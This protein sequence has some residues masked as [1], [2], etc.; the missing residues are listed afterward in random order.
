M[1]KKIAIGL[2]IVG[3]V[4]ASLGSVT[5][6]AKSNLEKREK[7]LLTQISKF[8]TNLPSA[9]KFEKIQAE[10]SLF[11]SKGKYVF[12]NTSVDKT[13]NS[14]ISLDYQAS[15]GPS[16]WFG[17]DIQ[18]V[19]DG[20][21]EG[22]SV[23][24][25]QIST[26]TNPGITFKV[27]GLLSEDSS[28]VSK[29]TV[30]DFN[31]TIPVPEYQ[32]P[33]EEVDGDE[34]TKEEVKKELAKDTKTGLYVDVKG[35][36][37]LLNF[38]AKTGEIQSEVNLASINGH[39]LEDPND[40]FV[41]KD[42]KV[43]YDSNINNIDI[44]IFK[45][46]AATLSNGTDNMK[47]DG[48]EFGINTEQKNQKYNM[49]INAKVQKLNIMGQSAAFEFG[50]S[51]HGIDKAMV[52][53]STKLGET[54]ASRAELSQ[55]DID[56]AREVLLNNLKTGFSINIDKAYLKNEKNELNYSAQ[57]QVV[58]TPKDQEFSFQNQSKFGF[59]F[60]VSGDAAPM[61]YSVFSSFLGT[62]SPEA[63]KELHVKAS[64][65][66][67]ALKINEKNAEPSMNETI[68]KGLKNI[69]IQL[70][71]AKDESEDVTEEIIEGQSNP[72]IPS[73]E[74]SAE[75]TKERR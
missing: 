27:E 11:S 37:G 67:G 4:A 52:D 46:K 73:S 47:I 62:T 10:S 21:V 68:L 1:N 49:K 48:L 8:K 26:N 3:I 14:Q 7:V 75:E 42:L 56:A 31:F 32:S 54:Y 36:N 45:V 2:G 69:D 9:Y 23:K 13:L 55:K 24:S 6:I 40:K 22:E 70:G 61:A 44:G 15:H 50:Y 74:I 19:I 17:G 39:D 33:V 30:N 34:T 71:F 43:S 38:N 57:F 28:I 64:F 20:K 16:A 12:T 65:E 51:I 18:F 66:N 58:P 60:K 25:Y 5:Y 53:L 29:A 72:L 41:G 35:S 63:P 59:D